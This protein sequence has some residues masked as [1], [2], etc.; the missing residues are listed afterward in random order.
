MRLPPHGGV[1]VPGRKIR[2]AF[3]LVIEKPSLGIFSQDEKC[4]TAGWQPVQPNPGIVEW[5]P[6]WTIL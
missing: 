2:D 3:C 5:G 1:V 4:F 6:V